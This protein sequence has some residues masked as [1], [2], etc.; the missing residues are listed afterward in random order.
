M[1]MP[2]LAQTLRRLVRR[3]RYAAGVVAS[4]AVGLAAATTMAGIVDALFFR[5]PAATRDPGRLVAIDVGTYPD[6]LVVARGVPAFAGAG[7]GVAAESP[8]PIPYTVVA[9]GQ[10]VEAK[11]LLASHT[12]APV[13]GAAM[14]RGRR[15]APDEDRPG[16]P[17]V[18][19][20][21]DAFWRDHF[22]ASPQVLGRVVRLAG[23]PFTVVGVAPLHFTGATLARAD[24]FLPIANTPR[25][26]YPEALTSRAYGGLRVVGRLAPGATVS[27][28]EAAATAVYRREN[29]GARWVDQDSLPRAVVRVRPLVAA[30][31]D[32]VRPDA[33]P[34]L[35]VALWMAGVAAVVLLVACANVANLALA[36]ALEERRALATR[37]ALGAGRWRL[38]GLLAAE[39]GVLAAAGGA[40]ALGLAAWAGAAVRE[41]LLALDAA[42]APAFDARVLALALGLATVAACA[43]GLWPALG[44]TR[45]DLTRDLRAGLRT[46]TSDA[47]SRL[48][49]PLVALQVGLALVLVVGAA[50]FGASLHNARAADL[51]FDPRGLLVADVDLR[52]AGITGPRAEALVREGAR[53]LARLPGVAVVGATNAGLFP[54]IG[55]DGI[56]PDG[57][58]TRDSLV[59]VDG[60]DVGYTRALRLMLRAGRAFTAAEVDAG[61]RVAL[62][63][64]GLARERWP[65]RSPL[66]RCVVLAE[67]GTGACLTVVGVVA[68]RRLDLRAATPERD[69]Y[70]PL[71]GARTERAGTARDVFLAGTYA[72]RLV[73]GASDAA[74]AAAVRRTL[75]DLVPAF[76]LVRV[77]SV[78][79]LYAPQLHAWQL[80][81]TLGAAFGGVA[82]ALALFGVH[83][84]V[85]YGVARRTGEL[86]VRAALGAAPAQL[87]GLVLRDVGRLAGVGVLLG[88]VGAAAG[89]R[90]LG[91]LL[92]GVAPLTP[93]PYLLAAGGLLA[94]ALLAALGPA[95]RAGR[96]APVRALA[97]D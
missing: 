81:A 83:A 69:V 44:G 65:G 46:G 28:A 45:L 5:P 21:A 88:V 60:V 17:H 87:V 38:A 89:A 35:R 78:A 32:L 23:E 75:A 4:L 84:T 41:R 6:Y 3:P 67:L 58:P 66:G 68:D 91:A 31:R 36:R 2:W 10:V 80:G 82:L 9:N 12:L 49:R 92:Y 43:A 40:L 57:V 76:P 79:E 30:R 26:G 85:S 51:G 74:V 59:T 54:Q 56:T 13:L 27:E 16:G 61:A 94:A 1:R 24:L 47:A 7:A 62:V 29:V 19:V 18:V 20:L 73:P 15:F 48:L 22:D 70:L 93:V 37:A 96:T 39:V 52:A 42:G 55:F 25:F 63:S 64:E 86:G 34:E 33:R 11:G 14:A 97:A 77:Q 53:G 8:R 90:G 72:L 71:A 95:R 50:L